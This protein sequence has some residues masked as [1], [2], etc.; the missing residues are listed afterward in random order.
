[1]S[2][3]KMMVPEEDINSTVFDYQ[4]PNS[5]DTDYS[6]VGDINE[7]WAQLASLKVFQPEASA[8]TVNIIDSK[9]IDQEH[10]RKHDVTYPRSQDLIDYITS[11]SILG[12]TRLMCVST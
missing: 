1:M 9:P 2:G 12:G 7:A 4:S 10:S 6:V 3:T 8:N 5:L 11:S